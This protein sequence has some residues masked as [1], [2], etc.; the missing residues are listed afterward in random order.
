[1]TTTDEELKAFE[2]QV[3]ASKDRPEEERIAVLVRLTAR[4]LHKRGALPDNLKRLL[5]N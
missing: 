5:D 4:F 2:E 3:I 1:M